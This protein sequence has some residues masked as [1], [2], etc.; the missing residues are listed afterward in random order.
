MRETQIDPMDARGEIAPDAAPRPAEPVS[1][2]E[3]P[4]EAPRE[5]TEP[6]VDSR[7]DQG[8]ATAPTT[9]D[10]AEGGTAVDGAAKPDDRRVAGRRRPDGPRRIRHG[11][12]LKKRS[13]EPP[14]P[15]AQWKAALE[16][17]MSPL[18][19]IEGLEYA[20][21]GQVVS[22][23]ILPPAIDPGSG[24]SDAAGAMA[25]AATRVEAA[26]QGRSARPYLTVIE[27]DAWSRARWDQTIE[28]MAQEAIYAAKLL[29][30]EL[31]AAVDE[32]CAQ[33]GSPLIPAADETFRF[34]CTCGI[35][36]PC[37]HHAA[38]VLLLLDRL[39][40]QP[41]LAFNLRGLPHEVGMA[42]L[43]EARTLHTHGQSTAHGAGGSGKAVVR[44]F[45]S[46]LGDFWRPGPQLAEL[47]RLAPAEYVAH[48]ILRRLG[49]SPFQGR[50][51]LV[52]LLASILDSVRADAL[53]LREGCD[54]RGATSEECAGI[55]EDPSATLD[56]SPSSTPP[57][58]P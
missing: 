26:V 42:R 46:C 31:P 16:A 54:G 33:F 58:P 45:E 10:L 7:G 23:L 56:A 55:E 36:A 14:W 47:Q 35:P 17:A 37:K 32:L 27:I 1:A 50:F 38:A 44:P 53:R 2:D 40:D 25:E 20:K 34:S 30:G 51:P 5:R 28:R 57:P 43:Q 22:L 39:V 11:L 18:V 52:G 15:A 29:A 3:Y 24:A 21:L 8:L 19:R 13:E 49:P 9:A 12:K 48:A 6:A 41:L 4:K